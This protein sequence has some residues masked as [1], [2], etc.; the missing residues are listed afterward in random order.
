MNIF[1][2][3]A[4]NYWAVGLQ[5]IPLYP[6]SKRPMMNDWS[7][8]ADKE[9]PQATRNEWIDNN[10]TANMGLVLGVTSG[11]TVIDIDTDDPTLYAAIMAVLPP[12][13][14]ARKGRKGMMLA[15]KFNGIKTHRVKNA[16]GETLVECLS[17]RTQ[18]VLP[19]SIHPNT[20]AA[21]ESNTNLYEVLGQL[22]YLPENIEE[23]LRGALSA[24]GAELSH[25]G[26][27]KV[28]DFVSSGARDTTLTEMAG[29]FAYAV[30]RG[31]RTL[32]EAIGMLRSYHGEFIEHSA[33]DLMDIEKHVSNLIKFL[34][35]DVLE[36]GKVL[37]PEWDKGLTPEAKIQLGVSLGKESTEWTYDEIIIFLRTEFEKDL[38]ASQRSGAVEAILSRIAKSPGIS[39]IDEDRILKYI[40][41]VSGM[42]VSIATYRARLK[43]LRQGDIAGNDHSEIARAVLEDLEQYSLIRYHAGGFMKWAGSHWV[44]MEL[45]FIKNHISSHYGHLTACKKFSDITGIANTLGI[46]CEH[47]LTKTVIKGVNFA[48]GFLTEELKLLPHNPDYGMMY[49]LPFRY[50]PELAGKFPQFEQFLLRSWGTDSDYVQKLAALQEVLAVTLFGMGSKFQRAI[51]LHGAP[52]SGKTQLLR[53][54]E[55][56]VPKEARC[57]LAPDGWNDKFLPAIMHKKVLNICGELSDRRKIEGQVFKDIID[58]SER[59]A[60]FKNQQVFQMRPEL[61]HWFASNHLPKTDDTSHGFIRRWLM[62][63]FHHPVT[64]V[65]LKLDIG[66]LIAAEEREAITAWAC[67][68]M[69]RLREL[70]RYTLPE[71]HSY[72]ETEFANL[73]NSVR[74]WMLE[75][76]RVKWGVAEGRTTESKAFNA[77]WSWCSA[78]G[79]NKPV[80]LI[81]FRTMLRELQNQFDFTMKRADNSEI[82]LEG[83]VLGV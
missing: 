77:Y 81:K 36:K 55:C 4:R 47:E 41:E 42:G 30:T 25:A 54:V 58:G 79:G 65:Q 61:T 60:Q 15:Y 21:Y 76:N 50:M 16:S 66:D 2:D 51:L 6:K 49:T 5:A 46:L 37:P 13:P 20:G 75:S 82:I 69:F 11:I 19:P 53:I 72:L 68:S 12:S 74:M 17:S 70:N 64:D 59:A 63:T 7:Q 52:R 71:S 48:N 22:Q 62:L 33:G 67:L 28:T 29:L 1:A 73:N 44:P 56:L 18:C 45:N 31:E 10:P 43:E 14:W 27:S 38:S 32:L 26:W 23:L 24:A 35:R 78:S 3:N 8:F 80:Q 57:S 39:R 34:E 9:I 83:L 40:I